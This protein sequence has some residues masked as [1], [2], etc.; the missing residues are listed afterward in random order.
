MCRTQNGAD[1]NFKPCYEENIKGVLADGRLRNDVFSAAQKDG[2]GNICPVTIILPTLVMEAREEWDCNWNKYDPYGTKYETA[3]DGILH[4][5]MCMLGNKIDEAIQMLIERY[6]YICSQ[7]PRSAKFMYENNLMAGYDGETV[8]SAMQHGT[9]AVGQIALAETL[10]LLIGKDHTTPEGMKLAKE[11]ERVFKNKCAEA[12]KRYNLNFGVYFSPAESLCYTALKKFREKYGVIPNVSDRDYFTNSTH[13]PVWKEISPFEKIDIESELMAYSS[14]GSICY[15]EL[16]SGMQKNIEA[17]ETLVNYAM[18]HG[19]NYFALNVPNDMCM[20]CGY[21]DEI[22]DTCPMCGS[23]DIQHL[24]RVTG[25]L[26]GDFKTSFNQGKISE[27]LDRI[28][29]VG[30]L[31]E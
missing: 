12:K 19:I 20:N 18:D 21:T 17:L 22:N 27:T 3:H 10:Q 25:Y 2:R 7:N 24:R 31:E 28:R 23:H 13:V 29:H 4:V 14:A 11:I 1:I 15:V 16:P 5:F 6:E 8:R 9:L 30:R 26:T